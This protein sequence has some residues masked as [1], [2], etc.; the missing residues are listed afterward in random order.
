MDKVFTKDDF[1]HSTNLQWVDI[2]TEEYRIYNFNTNLVRI[3]KP[4]LLNVSKS[5]GHRIFDD[6]GNCHYIPSGYQQLTWKVK[7]GQPHFV[8]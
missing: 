7:E 2:S 1:K 4:L 8:A 6:K 3:E 5:G